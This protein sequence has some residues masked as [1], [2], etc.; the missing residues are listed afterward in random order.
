[1]QLGKQH[2]NRCAILRF[3][4]L[5]ESLDRLRLL[6]HA[7]EL[8][9]EDAVLDV[10]R[11]QS[12]DRVAYV[13][14]LGDR[15]AGHNDSQTDERGHQTSHHVRPLGDVWEWYTQGDVANDP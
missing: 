1:M 11:L 7:E 2:G 9:S 14:D 10:A 3:G 6:L 4:D 15:R 5:N 8:R 13:V 12:L